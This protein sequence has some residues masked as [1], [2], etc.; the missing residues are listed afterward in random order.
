[1]KIGIQW[2]QMNLWW[3]WGIFLVEA[4]SKLLV[5]GRDSPDREHSTKDLFEILH[6]NSVLKIGKRD[7]CKFFQKIFFAPN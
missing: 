4:I 2:G 5:G 7:N 1:M 3:W 6:D